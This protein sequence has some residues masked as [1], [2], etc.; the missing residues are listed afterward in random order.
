EI[1]RING[2]IQIG[3]TSQGVADLRYAAAVVLV[4]D[5]CADDRSA[6]VVE[7]NMSAND[8]E[9]VRREHL[10]VGDIEDARLVAGEI[11]GARLND[12]GSVLGVRLADRYQTGRADVQRVH[13]FNDRR[14]AKVSV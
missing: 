11:D 4:A 3:V 14:T 12:D 1:D 7:T 5:R 8:V 6:D 10:I 13:R 9:R 2:E